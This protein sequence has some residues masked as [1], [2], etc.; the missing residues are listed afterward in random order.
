MILTNPCSTIYGLAAH[1]AIPIRLTGA[2]GDGRQAALRNHD[3]FGF[4]GIFPPHRIAFRGL[5]D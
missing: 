2:S 4:P 1:F 3:G 5:L